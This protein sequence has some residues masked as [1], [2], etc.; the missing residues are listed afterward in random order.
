MTDD[1]RPTSD[2][3]LLDAY[4]KQL[5]AMDPDLVYLVWQ[6]QPGITPDDLLDEYKRATGG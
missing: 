3:G 6:G 5:A 1:A 4:R 2:P